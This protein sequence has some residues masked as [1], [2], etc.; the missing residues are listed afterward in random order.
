MSKFME[1]EEALRKIT[2]AKLDKMRRD[3]ASEI[4][5]KE[6]LKEP[7]DFL[8]RARITE[9]KKAI[10]YLKENNPDFETLFTLE[11]VVNGIEIKYWDANAEVHIQTVTWDELDDSL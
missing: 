4:Q 9:G 6:E 11:I 1:V 10:K 7:Q 3:A 2:I 8:T 5:Y